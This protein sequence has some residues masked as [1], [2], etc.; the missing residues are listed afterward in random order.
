MAPVTLNSFVE[1]QEALCN[2]NLRQNLY[3]D[4]DILM[5][6]VL[7]TL[8]GEEHRRRRQSE[9]KLFTRSIT[10]NY[11]NII[12][13]ELL[14][15]MVNRAIE[16]RDF[17]LVEF[18]YL[19]TIQLTSDF[20]GVDRETKDEDTKK[21]IGIVKKFSEGATIA[22][23][24]LE[25]NA[26]RQNLKIAKDS[27]LRFL[28]PSWHRRK[29]LIEDFKKGLIT[30]EELP[31]DVLTILL[32]NQASLKLNNS[33]IEREVCFYLQ[34]GSHSTANSLVHA[35]N[36]ILNWSKDT[37]SL[38]SNPTLMQKC[39]HESLRLHPAS[40]V[41]AR[42]VT[43][44]TLIAGRFFETGDELELDLASANKDIAIFGR[45]SDVFNPMREIKNEKSQLFGLTFGAGVHLCAG[46]DLDGGIRNS[47]KQGSSVPQFGILTQI[48]KSLFENGMKLHPEKISKKET[49]TSRDHWECFPVT[50]G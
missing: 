6:D 17:D 47:N 3:E 48:L 7:L 40:A 31:K 15:Q 16:A 35:A 39:V 9:L 4:S 26:V 1:V 18:G 28:K 5:K 43:E 24:N 2:P 38:A 12:F 30:E 49:H 37:V 23:S 44:P 41:A 25:K 27:F 46:R 32:K 10:S 20:A 14:N 34:A 19:A 13:S 50:I 21:L 22:H 36:E 8:H 29:Q 45:D 11:E 42:K 33:D